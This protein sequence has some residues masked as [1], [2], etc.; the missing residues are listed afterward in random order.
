MA[1]LIRLSPSALNLFRDCPR[2]FWMDKVKSIRRPRGIFPSLPNG[3]DRVIKDY[4]DGYRKKGELP[5]EFQSES[6]K[7]LELYPDQKKLNLWREWRTGLRYTDMDGSELFG[8][9]DDLL[10]KGGKYLPFDYK[11]KGTPTS[12]EDAVKYY[13]NQINCYA[14]LLEANGMELAGEGY[15]LYYSP[16]SVR[17]KGWVQFQMQAIPLQIDT[18]LALATFREALELIQSPMP[19]V[20]GRCEYCAWLAKHQSQKELCG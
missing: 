13:S 10:V 20:K 16:K 8:A 4:F 1:K 2:C 17:E 11:T 6:F 12:R 15:L 3:M 7:G 14:L 19:E 18:S 5:P 9:I